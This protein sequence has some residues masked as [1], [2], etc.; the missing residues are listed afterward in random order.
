MTRVGRES[1]Q[2]TILILTAAVGAGHEA[3]GRELGAALERAGHVVV[4]ADGLRSMGRG[5]QWMMVDSYAWML[6]H[7]PW[8]YEVVFRLTSTRQAAAA[9]RWLTGRLHGGEMLA[10]IAAAEPDIIVSTYPLVTAAL[11][12]L[13]RAGRIRQPVIATISDFGAHPMWMSPGADLHLVPA[14]C[15]AAMVARKGGRAQVARFPVS[16]RFEPSADAT[17]EMRKSA[18]RRGLGLASGAFVPLIVG[19]AWGVGDLEG[20]AAAAVS[21]GASPIVVTGRNEALRARV[22]ARYRD[23]PRVRVFG[24]TPRMPDLM[25]SADCLI[26]NAGGVTCLEAMAID[27]PILIYRP[28]PG[29]GRLNARLMAAAGTASVVRRPRQLLELLGACAA[30]E[31][32]LVAPRRE[33]GCDP[34]AA[35]LATRAVR[36]APSAR[37]APF[38]QSLHPVRSIAV[39]GLILWLIFS[40]WPVAIASEKLPLPV[41]GADFRPG[42][43][44]L[45]VRVSDPEIAGALQAEIAARDLPVTLFVSRS[46]AAGLRPIGSVAVGVTEERDTRLPR[47]WAVWD[48]PRDAAETIHDRLGRDPAFFLPLSGDPDAFD[49]AL[50][51]RHARVVVP[52]QN[53]GSAPT[54]GV[55]VVET[56]GLSG[57]EAVAAM[58]RGVAAIGEA[59]LRCIALDANS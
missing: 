26:Q 28:L 7:A 24:W 15:S 38:W 51:P 44:A 41:V 35:I 29:H 4:S 8:F 43:A 48:G 21:A 9:S 12:R 31:R 52:E 11:G 25:A 49:L 16:P 58:E 36:S 1:G 2:K 47:P 56:E 50:K 57:A 3:T 32:T 27:L 23:D 37:P 39:I 55:V 54:P 45:A 18:A 10:I 34:V 20:A 46:G 40:S 59:G 19:G 5:T 6:G 53:D 14:A 17:G 13:T 42:T 33:A 30:G 22:S